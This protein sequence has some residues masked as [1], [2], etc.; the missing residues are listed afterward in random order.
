MNID[1]KCM[2]VLPVLTLLSFINK[3]EPICVIY[4]IAI[5]TIYD[6]ITLSDDVSTYSVNLCK[7]I[8]TLNAVSVDKITAVISG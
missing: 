3:M 7:A 8:I 1:I 4:N 2:D 5:A 6:V